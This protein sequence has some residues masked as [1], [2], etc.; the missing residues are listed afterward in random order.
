MTNIQKH[1]DYKAYDSLKQSISA[2]EIVSRRDKGKLETVDFTKN[3]LLDLLK[4]LDESEFIKKEPDRD[5][6]FDGDI[7]IFQKSL[8]GKHM[9]IKFKI[10]INGILK[11]ISFHPHELN[12]KYLN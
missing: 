2:I 10:E 9:Y 6:R 4:S 5:R 3:S 11:L 8:S 12:K 1:I 7:W